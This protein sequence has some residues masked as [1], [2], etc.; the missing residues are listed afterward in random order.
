MDI[1]SGVDGLTGERR[2][3][4]LQAVETVTFQALKPGLL[5]P[6]G[7][8]LAGEVSVADIGLDVSSA[9]IHLVESSDVAGW[10]PPR[11]LAAHKWQTACW[12]MA[13]SPA[14]T[15]AARLA[16]AAAHRSGAGYVR[17]SMPGSNAE[18]PVESVLHRLPAEG[19]ERGLSTDVERFGSVVLGPGLG[20]ASSTRASVRAALAAIDVPLVLDGDG[21]A[22][23][24]RSPELLAQRPAAT[25]VTPHDREFE[26]LTGRR[27][28][29]DRIAEARAC[30]AALGSVVLLKGPAT[31]IARPDGQALVV[32]AGDQRL[33]TAGTGD[34]LAGVVGALLAQGLDPFVAAAAGAWIHGE[35]G[36]RRARHGL[37]AGDLLEA[38]PEVLDATLVG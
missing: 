3:E 32:T 8:G 38:I 23:I 7:S 13:G 11:P 21:I 2:G 33:A 19:W 31:V 17:L 26:Y 20:R 34:V 6:P 15:G 35:A 22:A 5:L 36:R 12:V 10:L 16:A 14:M 25:V 9:T 29:P 4:P 18:G 1:P 30:A 37:V 24:S 27:P 28:A